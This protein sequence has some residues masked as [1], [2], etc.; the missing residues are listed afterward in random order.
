M[1]FL[2]HVPQSPPLGSPLD[3]TGC[4]SIDLGRL[5]PVV[6]AVQHPPS[7]CGIA[8]EGLRRLVR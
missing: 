8:G 6:V 2:P 5:H 4:S 1:H 3:A 7:P